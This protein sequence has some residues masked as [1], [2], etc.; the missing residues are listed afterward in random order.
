MRT[1]ALLTTA[2]ALLL[3]GCYNPD[4]GETPFRCA[5][6]DPQCPGGYIC[7]QGICV[8]SIPPDQGI[9][10]RKLL[11]DS[12]ILPSKEG[13]VF[14]DWA[15]TKPAG[16]CADADSE[17]NNNALDATD[18]PQG[19]STGWE[20]CYRGDVDQFKYQ[21]KKGESLTVKVDFTHSNGDLDAV[22]FDP[23]GFEAGNSRSTTSNE[24]IKIVAQQT[25][26]YIIGIWGFNFDTNT[27][28]LEV[29]VQ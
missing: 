8:T 15:L 22:I 17:P 10:D 16:T 14:L 4:L 28:D 11:D 9:P 18:L 20:I 5:A 24:E 1:L 7:H 2:T 23:D 21:L 3:G 27:Y 29:T 26:Y 19:L 25:G 6:D 12:Q 13:P